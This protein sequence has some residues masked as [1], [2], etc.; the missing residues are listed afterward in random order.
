MDHSFRGKVSDFGLSSK[1]VKAGG[2]I[3]TPYWMAPEVL[4]GEIPTTAADVYRYEKP[5]IHI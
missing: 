1:K 5:F 2:M 4:R 3:G